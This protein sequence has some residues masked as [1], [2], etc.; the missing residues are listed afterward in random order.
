MFLC[1]FP[2]QWEDHG[3]PV[4]QQVLRM[5]SPASPWILNDLN[6]DR[7]GAMKTHTKDTDNFFLSRYI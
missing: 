2:M 7:S 6:D 3:P 4:S 1:D 5:F